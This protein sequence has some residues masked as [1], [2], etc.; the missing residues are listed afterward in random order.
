MDNQ[1]RPKPWVK[2]HIMAQTE[3]SMAP[4][5]IIGIL[6]GESGTHYTLTNVIEYFDDEGQ[7]IERKY[8]DVISK[9]YVWRCE[10]IGDRLQLSEMDNNIEF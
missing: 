1:V 3:G 9:T 2:L 5:Y 7:P 8:P 6:Q 4:P 10:I